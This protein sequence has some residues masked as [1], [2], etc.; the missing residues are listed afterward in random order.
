MSR[1]SVIAVVFRGL[2]HRK[3]AAIMRRDAGG[4]SRRR[5]RRRLGSKARGIG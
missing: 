2:G 5:G 4:T 1:P 3:P